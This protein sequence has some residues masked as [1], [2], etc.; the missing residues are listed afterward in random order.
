MTGSCV[1]PGGER[2]SAGDFEPYDICDLCGQVAG[3]DELLAAIVPDSSAV[4]DTNPSLD[5][6][7]GLTACTVDHL[8]ALVEEYR[9]RPFMPEEQWAAKIR[10]ALATLD[11]PVGL[12][13]VAELSGL[14][15]AEAMRGID[16]HTARVRE[17]Q[18]GNGAVGSG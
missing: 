14:S 6:K 8:A 10:R 12:S 2:P 1:P 7:R 17:W 11:T 16:W 5:G 13:V 3:D 18:A 9:D 15:E 4:H